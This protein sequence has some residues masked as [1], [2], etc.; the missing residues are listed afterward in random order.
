M[1]ILVFGPKARYDAYLPDFASTLGAEVVF[2]Q[3]DCPLSQSADAHSDAQILFTDPI[4]D[5]DRDLIARLPNLKLIQSEGVAFNRIDLKAAQER[6]IFVCNNKGCNAAS[7]AEHTVMLMLM[8]LRH[9]IT[10]HN[11]VRAGQ[12]FSM[13]EAVMASCAP[14]LGL[15]RVGLVGF[16][17]IAQATARRLA[18]F[19]CPLFYYSLHRRSPQVEAD[20]G[21]TY[22]P[23][24]ELAATCD[25]LS[26]HCA[27]NDQ[28]RNLV[29]AQLLSKMKPTS[30]LVN[31]A[32]GDLVDNLAVRQALLDGR[33]GGIA[34]DTLAP[35][36]TPADHPL[37]DLPP[38]VADRAIYSPHL[39]GNTGG[40]FHRAHTNMWNNARL[41][42]EG[43]RPNF[44]VNG[45]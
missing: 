5:V 31:T 23:L 44:V 41:I 6:G 38:E 19:G 17:D 26:L 36:P 35:E 1:K 14:E 13:K 37:V 42:L 45:L 24:E 9:G 7:V 30:I 4:L 43:K 27:V 18:P 29:N 8:A 10:G 34:M 40:S 3:P 22:L 16:G 12:Q 33:L 21:V 15:S 2:Y 25:I 32:R 11:A 20:F 28:T 39:G